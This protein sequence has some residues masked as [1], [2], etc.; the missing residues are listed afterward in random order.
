MLIICYDISHS[1]CRFEIYQGSMA[2]KS[3]KSTNNI[4]KGCFFEEVKN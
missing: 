4:P 2:N 1:Q 3:N